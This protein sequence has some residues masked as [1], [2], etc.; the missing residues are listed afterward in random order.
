MRDPENRCHAYEPR[1]RELNDFRDCQGDGHYLCKE[2]CHFV[3]E[4]EQ[5]AAD[6]G[7]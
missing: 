4:D 2:C 6:E 7:R 5:A 1:P 3:K